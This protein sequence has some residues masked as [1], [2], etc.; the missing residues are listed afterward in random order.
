MSQ[1]WIYF[2]GEGA[3]ESDPE[4]KDILGGKGASL[5][6][7]SRAGLRVP[8]GFTISVEAC[9]HYHVSGGRWP[10]GLEEELR[11]NLARLEKVTGRAYG[12]GPK[13]LL[14]SVRSGAAVSM[15]GMMDTL[16]NCGLHPAMESEFADPERFRRTWEQFQ[17]SFAK[18][19]PGQ[20]LPTD[21]WEILKACVDAV[22]ESWNS[23]RALVYRKT[24][25]VRG[26][27]GTAV[28]VQQMFPSEVS[29]I[30]FTA[31][32]GD[33]WA[34]E[35]VIESSWGL[36]ESIVSG[37]VSPDMFVIDR[38]TLAVK[39]RSLGKKSVAMGSLDH[40]LR[41]TDPDAF[42][43]TDAEAVGIAR[44]A[45]KVEEYYRYPVDIEWGV[46]DG[47]TALLQARPVRGLDIAKDIETGRVEEMARLKALAGAK[48]KVWVVHNLSET[49]AAPTP[50]TWDVIRRFMTGDG[51]FGRM[52]RSLGYRPSDRVRAD[53]FLELIC[54][55]IYLDP[56]R[57]AELFWGGA[58][59]EY[60]PDEIL[61]NPSVIDSA[62]TKFNADKV[63]PTFLAY[64]PRLVWGMM[65]ASRRTKR[66]RADALRRVV[67]DVLPGYLA[68]ID[69][70][71]AQD[72]AA[73]STAALVAELR[74][75]ISRTLDDF[76]PES[77]KPGF[78]GGLARAELEK[79]LVQVLGDDKGREMTELVTSGLPGDT[80][81]DQ[82]SLLWRVSEGSATMEEFLARYGHRAAGEMELAQPRWRED[83]SYL[84]KVAA[85]YR[86]P[87]S[88]APDDL[89]KAN[90]AR[91]LAAECDL[92]ALLEA[93]GAS[94]LREDVLSAMREAQALLPWRET[95]KHYLMMGYE[96]IRACLVEL[97]R[98]WDL[99]RD[100]F[101]LT[102]D[103]LDR[104]EADRATHAAAIGK[105]KVRWQSAQRLLLGEVIDTNE[106]DALG[107]P[108]TV[109]DSR[110]FKGLGLAPGLAEGDVR[111][112]VRPDE[113]VDLPED[114]I[115]VAP[116][117]DPG[118]TALF[119]SIRGLIVER[120]GVLSHGAI[121]ARDF[122]IP[123]IAC[124]DATRLLEGAKRVRVD[125]NHGTI[126]VL[127]EN[128]E[129]QVTSN[130]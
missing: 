18:T 114:C 16:L 102:L 26:A 7:M 56:D 34:E 5:A 115:L 1:Q 22:F 43:L 42:S 41:G 126:T 74:A 33:P 113:A 46:S 73:L 82:N 59:L 127:D 27:L 116:S 58:P 117:T 129:K 119:A 31:N 54:G 19:V 107:R 94:S 47:E 103:E 78:F 14:V 65:R 17:R 6:A 68:W 49:V 23:D 92:P 84:A 38:K 40:G 21:P 8:P 95:G 121:T 39:D 2:F 57:A 66:A 81:F 37:D 67:H 44:L 128:G 53:G 106:L 90:T 122:G 50:M 9:V 83:A 104:F 109:A 25:D 61:R 88:R 96:T 130:E 28:T 91:R 69:E 89:H 110:E 3:S 80:T 15:P 124:H 93:A 70:K 105:R 85:S 86:R 71:R 36:G 97:A 120:G 99:G 62:P 60:D 35:I 125:G 45:L 108:R 55:R 4:R 30:A 111:I 32:P 52:Y 20:L 112:V 29:G 10:E 48:R 64:A 51:G 11:A 24:Q 72:L 98:R 13:P 123:A 100:V 77:L 12:R 87:G 75:R 63:E 79:L 101:F 118:W 76:G